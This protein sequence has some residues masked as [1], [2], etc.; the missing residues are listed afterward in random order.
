MLLCEKVRIRIQIGTKI[1]IQIR[2]WIRIQIGANFRIQIQ[3]IWIHSMLGRITNQKLFAD[4][5]GT[6]KYTVCDRPRQL[7]FD[8]L[9]YNC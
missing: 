8:L 9:L 2:T 5:A 7:A 1:Q 6:R 4:V 3:C